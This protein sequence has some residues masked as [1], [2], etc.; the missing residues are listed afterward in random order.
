MWTD[1]ESQRLR[2]NSHCGWT[3]GMFA[4]S[5]HTHGTYNIFLK[6]CAILLYQL[7]ST[8]KHFGNLSYCKPRKKRSNIPNRIV[9]SS[10]DMTSNT[11]KTSFLD[12]PGEIRNMIYGYCDDQHALIWKGHHNL[13]RKQETK[14]FPLTQVNQ[15]IRIPRL[16]IQDI[17]PSNAS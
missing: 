1:R 11:A 12:L 8:R 15:H 5:P 9:V 6:V 3:S 17:H 16:C 14:C 10:F 2:L 7:H 13:R 4:Q